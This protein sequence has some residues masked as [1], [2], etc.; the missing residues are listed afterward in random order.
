MSLSQTLFSDA[1]LLVLILLYIFLFV[2][3]REIN[4]NKGKVHQRREGAWKTNQVED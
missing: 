1:D 4:K 2:H 3:Y